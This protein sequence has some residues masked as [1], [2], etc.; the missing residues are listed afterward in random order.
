MF[1][2]QN[3]GFLGNT[4]SGTVLCAMNRTIIVSWHGKVVNLVAKTIKLII[5]A[6][7]KRLAVDTI[8]SSTPTIISNEKRRREEMYGGEYFNFSQVLCYTTFTYLHV[9]ARHKKHLQNAHNA[10]F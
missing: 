8:V 9:Y 4:K 6:S 5:G 2:V 7:E 10:T 3:R 1:C